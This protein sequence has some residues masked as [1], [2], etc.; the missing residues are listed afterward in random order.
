MR[1]KVNHGSWVVKELNVDSCHLF[2]GKIP[3]SSYMRA[4][5]RLRAGASKGDA[6]TCYVD[7]C[8]TS[9]ILSSRHWKEAGCFLWGLASQQGGICKVRTRL[10]IWPWVMRKFDPRVAALARPRGNCTRNLQTRPLFREGATKLQPRNCLKEISRKK[11]NWSQVPDGRLT[12]EQT[13]WLTVSRKLTA[14][15]CSG[16]VGSVLFCTEFVFPLK[17]ALILCGKAEPLRICCRR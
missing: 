15:A 10:K 8:F 3:R 5:R 6:G 13:G 2:Q 7:I 4:H 14:T 17:F 9:L 1:W 11:K 12:P 16:L